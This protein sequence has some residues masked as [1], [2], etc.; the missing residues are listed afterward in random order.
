[1]KMNH[2][3]WLARRRTGV[4]VSDLSAILGVNPYKTPIQV[5]MDKLGLVEETED[6]LPMKLGRKLEPIIGE[7]FTERT[8][9]AVIPGEITQHP[10][11]ELLIGTPDFLVTDKPA[12]M[13]AKTTAWARED[14]WGP[15]MTDLIPMHYLVQCLGYLEITGRDEWFLSLLVGGSRDFRIYRIPRND[16]MQKQLI[17]AAERFWRE[18]IE[19]Q[20]PPPLDATKSSA[21]Y[22]K[23]V[24]PRHETD[25]LRTASAEESA[26]IGECIQFKRELDEAESRFNEHKNQ[27]CALIGDEAGITDGQYKVTWEKSKDGERVDWKAVA[28]ELNPPDDLIARFTTIQEGSRRF[29]LPKEK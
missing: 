13:E 28:T 10:S 5:Y 11:H 4:A 14:E 3:Q 22:L 21:A 19:T 1:M 8:G 24:F 6:S 16:E 17:G 7:L 25:A 15:E 12:G 23:R 27:L 20:T 26:L 29:N 2:E 18:H 9:L